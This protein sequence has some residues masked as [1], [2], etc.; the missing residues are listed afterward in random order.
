MRNILS[1]YGFEEN[2]CILHPFGNGLI[3]NTW[4]MEASGQ[5]FIVQK[6]N[7]K[8]FS[9]PDAIA[10]N[11]LLIADHLKKNHPGYFFC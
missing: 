11:I 3:N 10:F 4:L 9:T 6:I 5:R 8:V 2:E 7:Q 1:Q